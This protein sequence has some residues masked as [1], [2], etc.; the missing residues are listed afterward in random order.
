MLGIGIGTGYSLLEQIGTIKRLQDRGAFLFGPNNTFNDFDLDVHLACDPAW[1]S[2]YGRIELP[3]TDQWHWN[4]DICDQFGY[5]YVEGIWM[6]GLWMAD[7]SKISYNHCSGAQLLNLA[8]NQYE[9][10]T[11]LLVG[12]D[13]HYDGPQRHY[14]SE[15]SD[16][17]GEYPSTLRKFSKFIK[18][19]GNDLLGNYKCIA[20]QQGLPRIVNCTPGSKLPWFEFGSLEEWL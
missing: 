8:C 19:D 18:P 4:R 13:F 16:Q 14:F 10:A 7:K 6:D 20:E 2:H 15:L 1:H 5:R 17:L 11:V 3:H 9:C 12:H